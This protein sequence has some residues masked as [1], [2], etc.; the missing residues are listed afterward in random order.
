MMGPSPAG[1]DSTTGHWEIAGVHLARPC[2]TYPQGFPLDVVDEFARRTD[3][4]V[5]GNVVA[6]GTVVLDSF[7][8][9]HERTR[10]WILYTSADSVFQV[11]AHEDVIPLDELYSGCE[12]ARQILV[13]PHDVSRVIARPFV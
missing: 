1:K 10:K 3:R 9:Q 12:I 5:I 7:G 8:P 11:A 4:G 13:G 6:S 2:P